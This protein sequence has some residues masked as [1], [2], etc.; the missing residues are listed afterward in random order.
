MPK[1]SRDR[2]SVSLR[3]RESPPSVKASPRGDRRWS[4]TDGSDLCL[5]D[6]DDLDGFQDG[7]GC[8]DADNDGDGIL[9]AADACPNEPEDF[10]HFQDS[11]G[12]PEPCPGGD[13]SGDGRVNFRDLVLVAR[14]FGSQPGD[15]RWNPS[16]DDLVRHRQPL[17]L[18]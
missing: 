7:D 5:D 12:C 10:D 6:P 17:Q 14:A 2:C 11:D 3:P 8:P 1:S 18:A 16:A 13:V 4:P 9:D 15:R